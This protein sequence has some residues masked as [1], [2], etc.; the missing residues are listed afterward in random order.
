MALQE[1]VTL[2][3]AS[4]CAQFLK[5]LKSQNISCRVPA[6]A[7]LDV[8]VVVELTCSGLFLGGSLLTK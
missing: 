1:D 3:G 5:A 8:E 4:S 7:K 6:R 2:K